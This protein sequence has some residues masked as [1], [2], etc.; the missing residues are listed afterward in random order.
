M[1]EFQVAF[2]EMKPVKKLVYL[3]IAVKRSWGNICERV[4]FY[5]IFVKEY[6]IIYFYLKIASKTMQSL[7]IFINNL[8]THK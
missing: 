1:L 7:N 2:S 4:Q 8:L 6:L 3:K 5:Q